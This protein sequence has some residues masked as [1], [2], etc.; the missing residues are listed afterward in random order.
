MKIEIRNLS[1]TYGELLA[2]DKL[3]ITIEGGMYGLLGP[4]GAGKTTLMK[5]MATVLKPTSGTVFYD[6]YDVTKNP[7]EIRQIIGYLPQEYGLYGDV[8]VIDFLYF[9]GA[10]KGILRTEIKKQADQI[11]EIVNLGD[12]RFSKIKT[13]SGGMK[14]RLGIAQA[15]LGNPEVI[16]VDEPTA[17]LDPEERIRFRN[18]LAELSLGKTVIL[19]THIISDI[20]DTCNILS[21]LNKG[22]ILYQ[23]NLEGL[24][25][26]SRGNVWEIEMQP[27]CYNEIREKYQILNVKRNDTG[28][29]VRFISSK[30]IEGSKPVE[31]SLE[32]GYY[33]LLNKVKGE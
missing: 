6:G 4:N 27:E 3:N 22:K 18:I 15:F 24:S 33:C 28:L 10:L 1:K 14:Q 23:G 26:Y 11:L 8:T 2:L 9:V 17:G 19:S 30:E 12:K 32:L 5:I 16:I 20:E 25:E 7:M 13:L 31:P 21:V 29:S